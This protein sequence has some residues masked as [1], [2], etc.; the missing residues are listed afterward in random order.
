MRQQQ[1][2]EQTLQ[3]APTFHPTAAEFEN[4]MEYIMSIRETAERFGVCWCLRAPAVLPFTCAPR[5]TCAVPTWQ[6]RAAAQ[7]EAALHA[8]P[9]QVPVSDA[10][11]ED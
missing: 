8:G 10:R 11:P 6:H 1:L 9:Q 7:L 3:E 5:L 4:P 2:Q